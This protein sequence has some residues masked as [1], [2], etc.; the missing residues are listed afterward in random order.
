[1]SRGQVRKTQRARESN[2]LPSLAVGTTLPLV[3]EGIPSLKL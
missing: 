2:G 1:M 3:K